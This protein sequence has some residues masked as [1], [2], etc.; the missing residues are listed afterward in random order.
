MDYLK[1]LRKVLLH[2]LL[3]RHAET[4]DVSLTR[5]Q[6]SNL[7]TEIWQIPSK[8]SKENFIYVDTDSVKIPH[9][10]NIKSI[11]ECFFPGHKEEIIEDAC[12]RIIDQEYHDFDMPKSA[13]AGGFTHTSS[14]KI[15]DQKRK[16]CAGLLHDILVLSD[17]I[18]KNVDTLSFSDSKKLIDE[19]DSLCK[20]Y[21]DQSGYTCGIII[22]WYNYTKPYIEM[23]ISGIRVYPVI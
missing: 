15:S 4:I 5:E 9:V 6:A 17:Y 22:D 1:A 16:E 14:S 7:C 10:E 3:S 20:Q 21:I 19:A 18:K 13:F 11:L 2:K 23:I 12:K 8:E